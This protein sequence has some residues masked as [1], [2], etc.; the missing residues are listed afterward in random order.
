MSSASDI[1]EVLEVRRL[2]DSRFISKRLS[3]PLPGARG[4]YGGQLV[5]QALLS[6]LYIVPCNFMPCSLHAYFVSGG[7]PELYLEYEVEELRRGKSFIHQ[8]VKCYQGSRL[9][10]LTVILWTIGKD[11]SREHHYKKLS[12]DEMEGLENM[13]PAADLYREQIGCEGNLDQR[14]LQSLQKGCLEYCFPSDMFIP[15]G[16]KDRIGYYV[17]VRKPIIR[18]R[19]RGRGSEG[20]SVN[21]RNDFRYNYVA[22]CYL[23][24]LYFLFTSRTF[25]G[26]PLFEKHFT[27]ISLDHSIHFHGLPVVNDWLYFEIRHPRSAHRR[28]LVQGEYY[29]PMTREILASTMQEGIRIYPKSK[30]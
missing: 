13:V 26:K 22:F 2:S 11:S 24:D 7:S 29:N 1:E 15:S 9:V 14:N 23:S 16:P 6:A 4:T 27:N 12:S 30:L 28:D 19:G 17:R 5:A 3:V 18:N 20:E 10:Y 21:P 8:Q 25:E